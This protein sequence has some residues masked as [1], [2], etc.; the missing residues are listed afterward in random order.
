MFSWS[1]SSSIQ[2]ICASKTNC[3]PSFLSKSPW[4]ARKNGLSNLPWNTG[5]YCCITRMHPVTLH[6]LWSPSQRIHQI[7]DTAAFLFPK[8]K[9]HLRGFHSDWLTK[10][11]G[12][13][14]VSLIDEFL[15]AQLPRVEGTSEQVCCFRRELL[16]RESQ[17]ICKKIHN[18][19]FLS[20]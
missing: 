7:S 8:L 5:A 14:Q 12:C 6:C 2:G 15:P 9:N 3:W 17:C 10:S 20:N 11:R 4:T 19:I 13:D 1:C 18:K 16:W